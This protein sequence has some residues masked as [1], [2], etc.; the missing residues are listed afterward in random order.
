MAMLPGTKPGDYPDGEA[1][2][3][4]QRE[5]D[6]R[7]RGPEGADGVVRQYRQ[8]HKGEQHE[9]ARY[10]ANQQQRREHIG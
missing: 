10:D 8:H 1:A 6:D 9:R 4:G 7:Q 3:A 2:A 5:R